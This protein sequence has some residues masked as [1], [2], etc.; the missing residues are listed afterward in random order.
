MVV[1]KTGRDDVCIIARARSDLLG[2]GPTWS[3]GERALY[4]VD[5]L[6][7]RVNRL[8]LAEDRV[9]EWPMPEMVG[10]VIERANGR[11]FMAGFASGVKTLTLEPLEI[12]D[13]ADLPDE[14][15]GNRMNDAKAD[16]DGRLWAGTMPITCDR[17]TGSLYRIDVDGAVTRVDRGYNVANGPAISPDGKRLFHTDSRLG[18][19]YRFALNDDGSLGPRELFLEFDREWGSP[20]GMTFDAEGGLWIA[21]W[22]GSRVSRFDPHGKV[23]RAVVLPASQ[24]TSMAFAGERLDRLFVTSAADGVQEVHGGAL[25]EVDPG[26]YGLAPCKFGG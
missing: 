4:W 11:G 5:I 26:C 7:R 17:P 1:G 2:E 14:P 6:G 19:V 10:W 24:I 23:E 25:F 12:A 15:E 18:L 8:A 22:G 20:D 3:P 16:R 9:D 13:F 21:H